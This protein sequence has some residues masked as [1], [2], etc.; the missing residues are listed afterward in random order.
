[1]STPTSIQVDSRRRT[2]SF[3]LGKL[4]LTAGCSWGT[5]EQFSV[6]SR[7]QGLFPLSPQQN[8]ITTTSRERVEKS[9]L[10]ARPKKSPIID[11]KFLKIRIVTWNMHDSLPKVR[12]TRLENRWLFILEF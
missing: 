11:P 8:G 1:M 7:L 3:T 2:V 6:L 10:S 5:G 9:A 12:R 4:L